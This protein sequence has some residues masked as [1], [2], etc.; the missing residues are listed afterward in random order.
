MM[1]ILLLL[2]ISG[3]CFIS[4]TLYAQ[5]GSVNHVIFLVDG[6]RGMQPSKSDLALLKEMFIDLD[7]ICYETTKLDST[8]SK[9]LIIPGNDH[10]TNITFGMDEDKN[11]LNNFYHIHDSQ[12]ANN[13]VFFA[14]IY[15]LNKKQFRGRYFPYSYGFPNLAKLEIWKYLANNKTKIKP[16]RTFLIFLTD[17]KFNSAPLVNEVDEFKQNC[18]LDYNDFRNDYSLST[19]KY[20]S[21]KT[22]NRHYEAKHNYKGDSYSINVYE[23]KPILKIGINDLFGFSNIDKE[24]KRTRNNRQYH[25]EI[26]LK[27]KGSRDSKVVPKRLII[28]ADY[29]NKT[30]ADTINL[31]NR[32]PG[33]SIFYESRLNKVEGQSAVDIAL[34]VELEY[35]SRYYESMT[36]LPQHYSKLLFKKNVAFEKDAKILWLFAI[37][38]FMIYKDQH[39]SARI[40]NTT[41]LSVLA[42]LFLL[43]GFIYIARKRKYERTKIVPVDSRQFKLTDQN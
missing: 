14:D 3:I 12:I 15:H 33:D 24:Y 18:D 6:S 29:D 4:N 38:D 17:N 36:L 21:R 39:A 32:A 20:L 28:N 37:P 30:Y 22:Y 10:L 35:K 27:Y 2:L 40:W 41:I 34:S 7:E 26:S 25:I 5:T 43:L 16:N 23:L 8:F 19:M 9:P 42:L 13:S 1:K 31:T 11:C